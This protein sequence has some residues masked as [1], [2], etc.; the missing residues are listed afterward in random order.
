MPRTRALSTARRSFALPSTLPPPCRA[1]TV[2]IRDSFAKACARLASTRS[3]RNLMFAEW[4]W[5]A[6]TRTARAT[7]SAARRTPRSALAE[8]RRAA[9]LVA[10]VLLALDLARVARQQAVVAQQLVEVLVL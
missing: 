6:M 2:I 3:L 10:A 4:E 5:P 1:A 9:R 7:R 8:L